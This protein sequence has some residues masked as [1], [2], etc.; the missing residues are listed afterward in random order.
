M[1]IDTLDLLTCI[2]P[3]C[4]TSVRMPALM[5]RFLLA[6][7]LLL[8]ALLAACGDE[9]GDE[10]SL[11]SDC[12]QAGDRFCDNT[13]PGGY[14]TVVGCDYDTCPEESVCVRFFTG[15]FANRTCDYTNEDVSTD[16]CAPSELCSINGYCVPAQSEARY[17]MK[18][19]S[20]NDDC[21]GDY[22]CR[23]LELMREHGGE[24]LMAPGERVGDNPARF[25]AVK[26]Q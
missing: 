25:C 20:S 21:R 15:G 1:R 10:C 19:C 22:E 18:A 26:P 11:S 5:P 24:P 23:T 13:Q 17:C 3:C 16:M 7:A 6:P 2:F 8:C 14:C 9:I 4:T 12:S